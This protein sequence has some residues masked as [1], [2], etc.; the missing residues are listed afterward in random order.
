MNALT[1]I[2]KRIL[3]VVLNIKKFLEFRIKSQVKWVKYVFKSPGC[4]SRGAHITQWE[5]PKS[6]PKRR[7]G[8]DFSAAAPDEELTYYGFQTHFRRGAIHRLGLFWVVS[9]Y[10]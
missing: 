3:K 7:G 10:F 6:G 4:D 1:D 2:P 5:G 8:G 9:L